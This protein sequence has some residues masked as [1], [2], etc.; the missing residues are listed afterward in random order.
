MQLFFT[1]QTFFFKQMHFNNL[2]EEMK[3][4]KECVL[5]CAKERTSRLRYCASQLKTIFGIDSVLE[6]IETPSW[7]VEE[8]PDYI[9][10]V[11]DHEICEK[12]RRGEL[13]IVDE[14]REDKNKNEEISD[15]YKIALDKMMDGVLEPK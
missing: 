8:I 1:N 3:R 14:D 4:A 10:T 7:N 12:L 5:K 2:F 6:P 11:K 15:F 9:V 13:K